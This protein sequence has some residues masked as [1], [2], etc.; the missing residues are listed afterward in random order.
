M[1]THHWQCS[2]ITKIVYF[3]VTVILVSNRICNYLS[4][5]AKMLGIAV[6]DECSFIIVG[7]LVTL[8]RM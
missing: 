8:K 2:T 4:I 1:S 5:N 6:D 3:M 7:L